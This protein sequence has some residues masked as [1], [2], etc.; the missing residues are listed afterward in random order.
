M[1]LTKYL[2]T[3]LM[4]LLFASITLSCKKD[5]NLL[6]AN[7]TIINTGD[8]AADGCGW[9]VKLDDDNTRYSP[10]TLDTA[11]QK[12]NLKVSISYYLLTT[13]FKCGFTAPNAPGIVQID[14]K[15][16]KLR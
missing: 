14:L 2:K 9:Q 12:N 6:T 3:T 4:V 1:N 10:K 8:V 15:S 13:R 5:Q 16:V 7:A 11:Y